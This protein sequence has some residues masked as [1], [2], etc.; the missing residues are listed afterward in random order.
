MSESKGW[1]WLTNT[2]KSHYFIN[3]ES[4]CG[5][6]AIFTNELAGTLPG[7]DKCKSCRKKLKELTR[8]E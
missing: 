2:Q 3:K 7:Q 4:L 8:S 1:H 5:S 6:W